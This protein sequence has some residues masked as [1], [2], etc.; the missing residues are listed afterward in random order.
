[1]SDHTAFATYVDAATVLKELFGHLLTA[2]LVTNIDTYEML[3]INSKLTSVVI[4]E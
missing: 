1:L 2:W 4:L 3:V